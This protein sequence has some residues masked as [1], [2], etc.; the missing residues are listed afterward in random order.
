MN[1]GL[2][3]WLRVSGLLVLLL[4]SLLVFTHRGEMQVYGRYFRETSPATQLRL[5]DLSVHMDEAAVHK[6]FEGLGFR[7]MEETQA[8]GRLGDRV[9]YAFI[10]QAD[11]RAALTLA[12][13]FKHGRLAH[14]MVQMP[15]WVHGEWWEQLDADHGPAQNT[16]LVSLLGVPSLRWKLPNGHVDFNRDRGFNPLAWNVILWTGG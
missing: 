1:N 7:C 5:P 15:W 6:H 2:P 14:A 9:C 4:L 3:P 11:G 16:G 13:F 12:A 10:D 8:A